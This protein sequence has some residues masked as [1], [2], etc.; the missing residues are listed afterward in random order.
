MGLL[1]SGGRRR[2]WGAA[3]AAALASFAGLAATGQPA[4]AAGS[5]TAEAGKGT[6]AEFLRVV[7]ENNGD[8]VRLEIAIRTLKPASGQGPDVALVGAVHIA[9]Q[10]FYDG[11]QRFLDSQDL[12]LYEAVKPSGTRTAGA[13]DEDDTAKAAATKRRIRL[14]ASLVQRYKAKQGSYP[15]TLAEL[16]TGLAGRYG[17][18]VATARDDG[19]GHAMVYT[20]AAPAPAAPAAENGDEPKRAARKP[21]PFDIVS[22]GADGR[23]GGGGADA[24]LRFAD[25]KA[26]SRSETGEQE[27]LQPKMAKA[28]GLVFQMQG[29]DYNRP[30]WRNSDMTIDQ[31]QERLEKG[32]GGG[33]ALFKLLD[34]S[35]ISGK[36]AGMIM[37]LIGMSPTTQTMA[38]L[39]MVDILTHA[40]EMLAAQGGAGMA[41]MM[42][43][44]IKDRN[45]V[46]VDD[47]R[48]VI[49]DEKAVK[50]VAIF[51]GAGHLPDLEVRLRDQLGYAAAGDQWLPA[52][53]VDLRSAGVSTEQ[54]KGVRQMMKNAIEQQLKAAKK[55][56]EKSNEK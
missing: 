12:V 25:Q 51:Y 1:H 2:V 15:A 13:A 18:I 7:E 49:N 45:Q 22:Y 55:S 53:E 30:K 44:I 6:G 35:S 16:E 26:L 21:R 52:I 23:P 9:D 56:A 41:T 50:T 4:G 39:M 24:D 27:G 29:V 11:V 36:L 42:E 47:L 37:S 31:V 5:P 54:A 38:K 43:V 28:L 17:S 48:R 34:G 20:L 32:G 40:D 19:W 46:V 8:R 33:E 10:K 3:C 14:L